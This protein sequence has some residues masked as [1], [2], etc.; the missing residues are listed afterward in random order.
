MSRFQILFPQRSPIMFEKTNQLA[1]MI[2][3][4]LSRRHFL[5]SLG[6]WAGATALAMAGVLTVTGRARAGTQFTCCIYHCSNCS[7]LA[8]CI[9]SGACQSFIGFPNGVGCTLAE[10]SLVNDC[11][12]C[13]VKTKGTPTC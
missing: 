11:K 6:R 4:H 2:A 10:S 8:S 1:E 9:S 12:K 7:S 3:T 13:T 5:G